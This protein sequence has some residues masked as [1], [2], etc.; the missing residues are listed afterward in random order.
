MADTL[1]RQYGEGSPEPAGHVDNHWLELLFWTEGGPVREVPT[2]SAVQPL[3]GLLFIQAVVQGFRLL[4][5]VLDGLGRKAADDHQLPVLTQQRGGGARHGHKAAGLPVEQFGWNFSLCQ[6]VLIVEA[7]GECEQVHQPHVKEL[8]AP[9][10]KGL[11]PPLGEHRLAGD[12]PLHHQVQP[13]VAVRDHLPRPTVQPPSTPVDRLVLQP[14]QPTPKLEEAVDCLF[15][16]A[17]Q[18]PWKIIVNHPAAHS[19]VH[20]QY[21]DVDVHRDLNHPLGEW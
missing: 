3:R 9:L 14:L 18:R 2:S 7:N 5:V 19:Q 12:H 8:A 13:P 1:G 21:N 11:G 6:E 15:V 10:D 20:Q 4:Q 17:L 16:G